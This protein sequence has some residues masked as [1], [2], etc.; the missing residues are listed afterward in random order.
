MH[1]VF[2][3]YWSP[4]QQQTG[5]LGH[6]VPQVNVWNSPSF[7]WRTLSEL[8]SS[9]SIGYESLELP[10][11]L[12]AGAVKGTAPLSRQLL[13]QEQPIFT[14]VQRGARLSAWQNAA[15]SLPFPSLPCP[16]PRLGQLPESDPTHEGSERVEKRNTCTRQRFAKP[17]A[18]APGLPP[19]PCPS[20]GAGLR[21][22]PPPPRTPLPRPGSGSAAAQCRGRGSFPVR[23]H[24][25]CGQ[26]V[27]R[28]WASPHICGA[29]RTAP[30]AHAK[31][32]LYV[33]YTPGAA[34]SAPN[35]KHILNLVC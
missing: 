20:L 1:C 2:F 14:A 11:S 29:R 3:V 30:A 6:Q 34:A 18:R 25:V 8:S 22:E 28:A 7:S 5:T 33:F 27:P 32:T 19:A 10:C 35:P 4:S 24:R 12:A 17:S 13:H 21:A 26:P 23:S 9:L 31:R 16:R 15:P